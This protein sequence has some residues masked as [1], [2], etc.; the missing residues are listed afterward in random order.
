M[1]LVALFATLLAIILFVGCPPPRTTSD[2]SSDGGQ[3]TESGVSRCYDL[4]GATDSAVVLVVCLTVEEIAYVVSLLVPA[5]GASV[6]GGSKDAGAC[7]TVPTTSVCASPRAIGGALTKVLERRRA[8]LY[9]DASPA[10][11]R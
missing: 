5:L 8:Q 4:Q 6:D 9:R 3:V 1:R 2:P 10:D 11:A 7:T